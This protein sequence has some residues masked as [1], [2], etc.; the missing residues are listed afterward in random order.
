M[1]SLGSA[2]LLAC[3]QGRLPRRFSQ[4]CIVVIVVLRLLVPG[5]ATAQTAPIVVDADQV[6]YEQ[7]SQQIEATGNV[8]VQYRGLRL[9]AD[10]VLVYVADELLAARGHVVVI[11]LQGRE[12]H[13]EAMTYNGRT[14]EVEMMS[15]QML[16]DRIYIRSDQLRASPRQVVGQT[17]T[18]TTCD[19]DHPAYRITASS[20][21]VIPGDRLVAHDAS[22]WLGGWKVFTVGEYMISLRSPEE[23]ARSSVPRIGY[24]NFDGLWIDYLRPYPLGSV[25]GALYGKY[26]GQSGF[27]VR[28]TLEYGTPAYILTLT[29]GRNQ[30]TSFRLYD[31]AELVAAL[32]TRRIGEWPF[33]VFSTYSVGWFRDPATTVTSSRLQYQVGVVSDRFTLSP[34]TTAGASASSLQATYGIG[35][36]QGVLRFNADLTHRL[37]DQTTA[38]L[39][40]GLVE[41]TG[42]SPFAFDTVALADR[43]HQVGVTLNHAGLRLGALDTELLVGA[44]YSFRDASTTYT[45][46]FAI[47]TPGHVSVGVQ[48]SYNLSTRSYTDIDY[49]VSTWICD[50]FQASLKYRQV[51]QQIWLEV[52][53]LAFLEPRPLLPIFPIFPMVPIT[54]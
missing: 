53:V 13:G 45:A 7:L 10:Y 32:P 24:D 51:R 40:Y 12:L 4:R 47:S 30:D 31:Q 14:N 39:S 42:S 38:K 35:A 34:Q 15:A 8:R 3:L 29:V 22:L 21:D 1:I 52:G 49:F 25:K 27:I 19:P 46:G 9:T 16:V 43:I 54:P 26:G 44:T 50:C 37:G 23:T 20:V 17:V 2:G 11:D 28:N 5:S 41:V 48:A 6:V 36:M 33:S 18:V